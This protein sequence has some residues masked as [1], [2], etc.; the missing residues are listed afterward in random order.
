MGA[1]GS[2]PSSVNVRF[3]DRQKS[4]LTASLARFLPLRGSRSGSPPRLHVVGVCV[5]RIGTAVSIPCAEKSRSSRLGQFFRLCVKYSFTC[6]N[7]YFTLLPYPDGPKSSLAFWVNKL[8]DNADFRPG[9]N[10][11]GGDFGVGYHDESSGRHVG[12]RQRQIVRNQGLFIIIEHVDID[13]AG[14]PT[15]GCRAFFSIAPHQTTLPTVGT[16]GAKA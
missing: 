12:V 3:Q 8:R 1:T 5:N 2:V 10:A 16:A 13:Y 11:L 7:M 9:N 4:L 6:V 15:H 14:A